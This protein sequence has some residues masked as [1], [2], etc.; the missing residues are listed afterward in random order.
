MIDTHAHLD[1]IEYDEDRIQII[2]DSFGS[3]LEFIIIPAVEPSGFKKLT[4]IVE[5]DSRLYCAYGIHPHNANQA[6]TDN[7]NRIGELA[8]SKKCVAIGEIGLDYYYDFVKPEIQKPTFQS[9]LKLAKELNLPVII[10]N[11]DSDEDLINIIKQEQD[12]NLK[13]VLHCY[14]STIEF[15]NRA[16]ELGLFLSFTGNITFKKSNLQDVILQVPLDRIML[17][18]DSPYMTPVPNRGKRNE[19]KNVNIIAQKIAEIKNITIDEVITMTNKTAKSFFKLLSILA[20]LAFFS[21]SIF[22]QNTNPRDIDEESDDTEQAEQLEH[23]YPKFIGISPIIGVNTIIQTQYLKTGAEADISY[24]GIPAFGAAVAFST[25]DWL[26]LQATYLYSKNT[27]VSDEWVGLI[28]PNIHQM[29]ELSGHF[30][31]NPYSRVCF[32]G[33]VGGTL[34]L[35]SYNGNASTKIGPNAGLGFYFNLP[36]DFGLFT[37]NAEWKLNFII[38]KSQSS[39]GVKDSVD[40]TKVVVEDID[41]S[42]IFSIPRFSLHFY[43]AFLKR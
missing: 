13:G 19:P 11:R 37:I 26:I 8:N 28:K 9:Q 14:S 31:A 30:V 2:Q 41:V 1:S 29:F 40:P 16:L 20:I 6:D 23:P 15:M 3:G 5:L 36:F 4:E 25:F 17:E 33:I 38:G 24:E 27:K 34:F 32:Y 39:R 10:H 7:L 22:A 21:Y 43:P 12:G 35:N 18:T 42:E